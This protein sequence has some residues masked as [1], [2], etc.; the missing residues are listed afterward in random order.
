MKTITPI[1]AATTA[2]LLLLS[3]LVLGCTPGA[4]DFTS[5]DLTCPSY[6]THRGHCG[7]ALC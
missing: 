6:C 5:S 1:T 3:T 4:D 7:N 2:T